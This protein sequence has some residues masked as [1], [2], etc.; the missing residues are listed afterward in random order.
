MSE[1]PIQRYEVEEVCRGMDCYSVMRK[2]PDGD[3]VMHDDH[4][5]QLTAANARIAELEKDARSPDIATCKLGHRFR[6]TASHP[7]KSEREWYCPHCMVSEN[8]SLTRQLSE[9]QAQ[10]AATQ[11]QS[12]VSADSVSKEITKRFFADDLTPERLESLCVALV[13]PI[14]AQLASAREDGELIRHIWIH[15][16]YVA[17]GYWQMT[18]VQK[19]RFRE[20]TETEQSTFD[21]FLAGSTSSPASV[22]PGPASTWQAIETA[23]KD[24]TIVNVKWRSVDG[25][26]VDKARWNGE[27]W[28]AVRINP[29]SGLP[30]ICRNPISWQ[31][32]PPPPTQD[33]K[34]LK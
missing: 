10:L 19:E 20:I 3:Y 7:V 6:T 1:T 8:A 4:V 12:R 17:C 16:A 29:F 2:N 15:S 33:G 26:C 28:V 14:A 30:Y 25:E 18:A 23:P 32:L 34:E 5:A 13:G 11:R 22:K 31:P 9:A 27:L 21:P 24:G